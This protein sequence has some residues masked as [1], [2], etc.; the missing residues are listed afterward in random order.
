MKRIYDV[1]Q[2][3]IICYL[4][5]IRVKKNHVRLAVDYISKQEIFCLN[6]I[7]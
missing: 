4:L 2:E 1:F 5:K 3:Q 7:L 6:K